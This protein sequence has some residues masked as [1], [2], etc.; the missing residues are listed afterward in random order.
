[1]APPMGAQSKARTQVPARDGEGSGRRW[2]RQSS[3]NIPVLPRVATSKTRRA[4]KYR[5]GTAHLSQRLG[6]SF[7][8]GRRRVLPMGY[9]NVAAGS[10]AGN[11]N[12]ASE[13]YW[14]RHRQGGRDRRMAF[15]TDLGRR[16][17]RG[18][19]SARARHPG[20][21]SGTDPSSRRRRVSP[22]LFR[23]GLSRGQC[24]HRVH[25][26]KHAADAAGLPPHRRRIA[27][28]WKLG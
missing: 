10:A 22:R 15:A 19:G 24:R 16:G 1:M 2:P 27:H 8:V 13:Q 21:G 23:T 5:W 25:V 4:P 28:G 14:L 18:A 12:P 26:H 7:S 20:F 11:L 9:P 17:R 3:R 6:F